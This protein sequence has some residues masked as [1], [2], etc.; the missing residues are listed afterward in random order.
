M[1]NG[2]DRGPSFSAEDVRNV[3]RWT[4]RTRVAGT[5]ARMWSQGWR[6]KCATGFG[7]Q[8]GEAICSKRA[9]QLRSEVDWQLAR[10]EG[11]LE[12]VEAA[13]LQ[14]GR[15][16]GAA[17]VRLGLVTRHCDL[18]CHRGHR[19]PVG[20]VV[21]PVKAAKVVVAR[22]AVRPMVHVT[23]ARSW[24]RDDGDLSCAAKPL[25]EERS[26]PLARSRV[27]PN[28]GAARQH[29]REATPEQLACQRVAMLTARHVAALQLMP[30]P[31]RCWD[32]S[33][34]TIIRAVGA[35]LSQQLRRGSRWRGPYA[36]GMRQ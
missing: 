4:S 19:R 16:R 14:V 12:Q 34:A 7:R 22:V 3:R 30:K 9:P 26:S 5:A 36:F 21:G 31:P 11:A 2:P 8:P 20:A 15:R 28:D 27:A 32:V 18:S 24:R 33:G 6:S 29:A 17:L 23:L 25:H 35:V 10:V 13:D 1:R